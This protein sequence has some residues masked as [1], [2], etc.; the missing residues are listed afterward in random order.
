[1]T[2]RLITAVFISGILLSFVGCT[3]RDG[4]TYSP[5]SLGRVG[6]ADKGVVVNVRLV[7]VDG[8]TQTGT[9]LGGITGSALGYEIGQGN[10]D[11]IRILSTAGGA[12]VGGLV[13]GS[14]EKLITRTM[15]YEY[16]VEMDS[17]HLETIV[18]R[19]DDSIAHGQRVILLKGPD[20]KIIPDPGI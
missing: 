16:I 3:S 15:A 17:G 5:Q 11:A 14:T 19:D 2:R 8:T 20:A 10:S 18:Q 9:I 4:G 7:N 6:R 12:M 13:G 1:M